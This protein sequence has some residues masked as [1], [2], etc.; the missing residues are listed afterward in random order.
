[1]YKTI[2]ARDL[3]DEIMRATYAYAEPGVIFIDR[4]NTRNN[5]YYAE[6]ITATNPCGEQP[7]PA[8]GA[9]LLGS[10]NL[11]RFIRDPFDDS[12]EIDAKKLEA[13]VRGAVRLLDNIIDISGY[14][15]PEQAHEARA[16]RR[17]GLGI[18]GLADALIMC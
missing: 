6:T 16:K 2:R 12:A 14:P 13:V 3:W 4:I 9:C 15:L 17:I 1:L 11:T 7:L 18:T 10:V 8:Y 5:L